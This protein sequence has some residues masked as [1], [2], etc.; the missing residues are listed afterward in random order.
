VQPRPASNRFSFAT[1]REM[2][3]KTSDRKK[4]TTMLNYIVRVADVLR[5]DE[6]GATAI[7]YGL[8]AGLVSV[9]IIGTLITLGGDLLSVFTSIQTG[10]AAVPA[11]GP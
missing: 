4:G 8:I 1:S 2:E 11:A 9:V 10:L 7:E 6:K 3:V 5:R